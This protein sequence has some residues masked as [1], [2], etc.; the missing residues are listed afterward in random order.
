M[1]L[2]CVHKTCLH[3]SS[4]N[5]VCNGWLD[6]LRQQCFSDATSRRAADLMSTYATIRTVLHQLYDG[7]HEVV[8]KLLK[9]SDTREYVLQYLGDVI[10]K[11]ATRSQIQVSSSGNHFMLYELGW[12]PGLE[13]LFSKPYV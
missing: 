5:C 10:Q 2:S 7:L 8:L 11:N 4:P 6:D 9:T 13:R 3:F 1:I 12:D